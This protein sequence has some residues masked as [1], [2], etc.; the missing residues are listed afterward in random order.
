MHHTPFLW[1]GKPTASKWCEETAC[2]VEELH[3]NKKTHLSSI[4][5]EVV[6]EV[7]HFD[8]NY[9]IPQQ[10]WTRIFPSWLI[11]QMFANITS[12]QILGWSVERE[13]KTKNKQAFNCWCIIFTSW[14][15]MPIIKSLLGASVPPW[16][17]SDFLAHSAKQRLREQ[18]GYQKSDPGRNCYC[19]ACLG[20]ILHIVWRC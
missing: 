18:R 5:T 13:K 14:R 2:I 7:I 4:V 12:Q 19:V 10:A 11:H 20:Q 16:S 8:I 17:R 15:P 9:L 1:C 6:G 3:G